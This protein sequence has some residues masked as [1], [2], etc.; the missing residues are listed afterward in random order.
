MKV[1]TTRFGKVD[2]NDAEMIVFPSGILGF[3]ECKQY[4]LVPHPGGG[5]CQWLQSCD[6]PEIAFVICEPQMFVPDY[7]INIR[8]EDLAPVGAI[9]LDE[10]RVWAI[11]RVPPRPEKPTLNLAGPLILNPTRRLGMQFVV[12]GGNWSHRHEIG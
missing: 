2:V 10:A 4:T 6:T 9:S 1:E 5:P 11:M 3:P 8:I 7:R 12:N